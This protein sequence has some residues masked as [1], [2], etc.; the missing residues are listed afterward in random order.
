MEYEL[1]SVEH[2][3]FSAPP[4]VICHT[5]KG[6]KPVIE[7]KGDHVRKKAENQPHRADLAHEKAHACGCIRARIH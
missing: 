2:A 5:D 1:N 7:R 6:I 4:E 3:C